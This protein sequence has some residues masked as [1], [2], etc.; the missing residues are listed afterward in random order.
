MW[1]QIQWNKEANFRSF[2]PECVRNC[3][4][5]ISWNIIM[6]HLH[7]RSKLWSNFPSCKLKNVLLM[8][9][10]TLEG[11]CTQKWHTCKPRRSYSISHSWQ[12][13]SQSNTWIL[14]SLCRSTT[15]GQIDQNYSQLIFFLR[16]LTFGKLGQANLKNKVIKPEPDNRT[17]QGRI[18]FWFLG[19]KQRILFYTIHDWSC[20]ANGNHCSKLTAFSLKRWKICQ[21]G[22]ERV[23][24]N[25]KAFSHIVQEVS[26]NLF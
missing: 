2:W 6:F 16:V 13:W 24:R 8:N 5:E 20:V 19:R 15:A 12:S 14:W 18:D 26:I 9:Q 7:L 17:K 21:T 10:R 1:Q 11:I 3:V 23:V 4:L 22:H 25:Y